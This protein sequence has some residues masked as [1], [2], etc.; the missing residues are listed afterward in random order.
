MSSS[1]FKVRIVFGLLVF[2]VCHRFFV[3]AHFNLFGKKSTTTSLEMQERQQQQ[4]LSASRSHLAIPSTS[5][6]SST[7]VSVSGQPSTSQTLRRRQQSSTA[8][9]MTK[10]DLHSSLASSSS[11][12]SSTIYR[13]QSS[14]SL[15]TAHTSS[16]M[17]AMHTPVA[18][19]LNVNR[20]SMLE[21]Q[22]RPSVLR[23]YK[24]SAANIEQIKTIGKYLKNAAIASAG[25]AG[26]ITIAD[27]FSN[28]RNNGS[29][30][31]IRKEEPG[32]MTKKVIT[33]TK[34]PEIEVPIGI[35]I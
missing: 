8:T 16:I 23:R 6:L 3:E 18:S 2:C 11:D 1:L 5:G 7:L 19:V 26:I 25:T 15:N 35:H 4:Q 17:Q 33:T 27:A 22:N 10:A 13:S 31:E 28:D 32:N 21:P 14:P 34:N 9:S 24:P 20:L 29:E 30:E 12:S